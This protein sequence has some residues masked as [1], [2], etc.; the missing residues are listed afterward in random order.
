MI[1][2]F[3]HFAY[4][5]ISLKPFIFEYQMNGVFQSTLVIEDYLQK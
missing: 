2:L 5:N 3:T 1:I 4:H